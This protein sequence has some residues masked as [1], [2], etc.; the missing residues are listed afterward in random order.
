MLC[1]WAVLLISVWVTEAEQKKKKHQHDEKIKTTMQW[2]VLPLTAGV[3][4]SGE[5][6]SSVV[7][8]SWREIGIRMFNFLGLREISFRIGQ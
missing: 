5:F 4:V 1:R 2:V 8:H 6:V 3:F 7:E